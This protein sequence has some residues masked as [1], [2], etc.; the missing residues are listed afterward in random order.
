MAIIYGSV[1][2]R[3]N[4]FFFEYG[5]LEPY[6]HDSFAILF[7]FAHIAAILFRFAHIADI[8]FRFAHIAANLFRL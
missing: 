4:L 8:L 7:R 2:E 5:N 1:Y 6:F 3:D